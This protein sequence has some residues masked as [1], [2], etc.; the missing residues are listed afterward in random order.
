MRIFDFAMMYTEELCEPEGA[1][2]LKPTQPGHTSV[3]S[4]GD[5]HDHC[6]GRNDEFCVRV[7]LF[8][9]LLLFLL[10]VGVV[11]DSISNSSDSSRLGTPY[12]ADTDC[13]DHHVHSARHTVAPADVRR[14]DDRSQRGR[15]QHLPHVRGG[16]T[17]HQLPAADQL[18]RQLCPLSRRQ[19]R[20][21]PRHT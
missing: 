1:L 14:R 12:H 18:R 5:S 2:S 4:T 15:P 16:H 10:T 13:P 7:D 9:L 3:G 6:W 20:L 8:L 11:I 21:P 19:R 17:R